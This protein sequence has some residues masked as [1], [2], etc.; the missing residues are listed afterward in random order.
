MAK[1]SAALDARVRAALWEQPRSGM[2]WSCS[3]GDVIVTCFVWERLADEALGTLRASLWRTWY[4]LEA[5]G[6]PFSW[7]RYLMGDEKCDL[8]LGLPFSIE[9][10]GRNVLCFST[11][12][13][14]L[15]FTDVLYKLTYM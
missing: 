14:A 3:R 13:S 2:T 1:G 7:S 5:A 10:A 11:S 6:S 4:P 15:G 12:C 9:D 8:M